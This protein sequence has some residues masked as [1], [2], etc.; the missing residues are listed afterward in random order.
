VFDQKDGTIG[1]GW[2]LSLPQPPIIYK[3]TLTFASI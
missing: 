2:L 3:H 1:G